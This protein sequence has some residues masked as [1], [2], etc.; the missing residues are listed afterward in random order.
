MTAGQERVLGRSVIAIAGLAFAWLCTIPRLIGL[1]NWDNAHYIAGIASGRYDWSHTPWS[2]HLGIGQTYLLGVW[3]TRAFGGTVID[4]FR[5]ANGIYFAA[6]CVILYDLS[7]R[8]TRSHRIAVGLVMLWATAWVNLHYHFI[9]EDNILFLAPCAALLSWCVLRVDAWRRRDSLVC[10]VLG[11]L[12]FLGSYQALPYLGA[13]IWAALISSGRSWRV[14][15]FDATC[16]GLAFVGALLVW[17]VLSVATSK[18]SW[19]VVFGQV[20]MGPQPNFMPHSVSALLAYIF[21]GRS[22][23]ETLGNGVV[24]NLSFHA[25]WLPSEPPISRWTLG[26]LALLSLVALFALATRWS[27]RHRRLVPH[28]LTATLLLLCFVTS[29]H[30]DQVQY[31]GL[32]RYDCVPLILTLLA[33]FVLGERRPSRWFSTA[34]IAAASLVAAVQFSLGVRWPGHQHAKFIAPQPWNQLPH[35]ESMFYGR[36]GKSWFQYFR[37][38]RREHR[39]A[40]QIVLSYAEVADG[41]WNYD[42]MAGLWSEIP[43]HLTIATDGQSATLKSSPPKQ[44]PHWVRAAEAKIPACA[45]ISTEATELLPKRFP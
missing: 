28:L 42:V 18:L 19:S 39:D 26:L 7:E 16:T 45:W 29:L 37:D 24:W 23:F 32:K 44:A 5:A 17:M 4:G 31:T 38:L 27:M 33:A 34:F 20:R 35:P 43:D 6:A 11:L 3:L 10:G 25:Y 41:T 8:L 40:C 1:I 15:L 30:R 22:L 14:R 12:A 21:D 9:L 2:S 13:P 36:E